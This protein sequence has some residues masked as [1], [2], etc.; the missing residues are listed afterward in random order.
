MS[1]LVN[2]FD[3]LF[4]NRSPL[5]RYICTRLELRRQQRY[6]DLMQFGNIA[7]H[8]M[9]CVTT[10]NACIEDGMTLEELAQVEEEI[11]EAV[12][13]AVALWPIGG[14][15]SVTLCRRYKHDLAVQ[16]VIEIAVRHG[17]TELEGYFL[18][19]P[20]PIEAGI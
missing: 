6:D 7:G 5:Q 16:R 19:H 1:A 11:V 14:M 13:A 9:L 18:A 4:K 17:F 10:Q 12:D 2:P 8:I 3:G 15:A 20:L